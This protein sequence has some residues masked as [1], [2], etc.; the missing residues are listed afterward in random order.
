MGSIVPPSACTGSEFYKIKVGT[1]HLKMSIYETESIVNI[2]IGG[3]KLYCIHATINKEDSRLVQMGFLKLAIGTIEQIYYNK[4]CSLEHNFTQG[5]DTNMIIILLCQY[6]RDKYPYVTHL[7]FNDASHR[8]C[9]NGTEVSLMVMTFLYS[10]MT[11]YQ[12]NFHAIIVPDEMGRYNKIVKKYDDEK[13][14]YSW[15][16]FNEIF[17]KGS[18]PLSEEKMKTLY[19]NAKTWMDFF[20]PLME[21]IKIAEFCNFIS[22]WLPK[23][24]NSILKDNFLIIPYMFILDKLRPVEYT[25]TKYIEGGSHLGETQGQTPLR[26]GGKRNFTKKRERRAPRNLM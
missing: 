12:K 2:Y 4:Q 10:G 22:P 21:E 13:K 19:D 5:I 25:M 6:V 20:K 15:D 14:K 3:P 8:S 24:I 9:E 7:K 17:I 26:G 23:F 1:K 18:L 16:A 11:W